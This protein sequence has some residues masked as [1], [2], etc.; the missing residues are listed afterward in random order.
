MADGFLPPPQNAPDARLRQRDRA[1]AT[2]SPLA[3][4]DNRNP[5]ELRPQRDTRRPKNKTPQSRIRENA[6][7]IF[8]CVRGGG[9][10]SPTLGERASLPAIMLANKLKTK[11]LAGL[12]RDGLATAWRDM[13]R[14]DGG[15][16]EVARIAITDSGRNA[17]GTGRA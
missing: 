8:R 12:I 16:V 14:A 7:Q 6:Q 4:A 10:C 11:M 1:A 15:P 3:L 13:V 2:A 9:I 5:H 17:L